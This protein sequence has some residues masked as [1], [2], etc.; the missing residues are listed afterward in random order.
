MSAVW[1]SEMAEQLKMEDCINRACPWS[2]KAVSTDSLMF[3]RGKTIGFC[4]PDCRDK[5]L[6]ASVS[7][8]EMIDQGK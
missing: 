2:G 5:F 7:F 1:K 4:N 3:Y 6:K 8:D